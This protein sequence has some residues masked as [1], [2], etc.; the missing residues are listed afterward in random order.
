MKLQ[1]MRW[2]KSLDFAMNIGIIKCE[3]DEVRNSFNY[4]YSNEWGHKNLNLMK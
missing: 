3:Y 2:M 1:D 4:M